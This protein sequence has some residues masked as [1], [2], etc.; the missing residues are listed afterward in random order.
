MKLK[1]ATKNFVTYEKKAV[2]FTVYNMYK[3]I[4]K[5]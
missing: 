1:S 3:Y 5:K 4:I 2:Y